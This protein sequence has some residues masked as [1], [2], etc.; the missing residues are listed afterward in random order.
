MTLNQPFR[1]VQLSCPVISE[2]LWPHGLHHFRIPCPLPTPE[3]CSNS[4]QSSRWCHLTISSSV[5]PVFSCLQ[6]FPASGSFLNESVLHIRWTKYWSFSF[7]PISLSNEY[8]RL[9]SFSVYWIDLLAV[10]ATLKS[11]LQH[12]SSKASI[13]WLSD[14]FMVQLLH[15][16]LTIGKTIALTRLTFISKVMFLFFFFL[17]I[18]IYF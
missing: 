18:F 16:Y 15:P 17:N 5:V 1:T 4:C 10:Q 2:F 8:S 14:F 3:A 6:S 7:S 13:L 12:H 11:L 9:I